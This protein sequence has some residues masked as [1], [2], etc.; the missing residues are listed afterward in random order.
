MDFWSNVA[1]PILLKFEG[2]V[3][4]ERQNE[5]VANHGGTGW[6]EISFN[7]A[8]DAT[9]SFID[10]NQGV[11][12]PFVPTGQYAT[13]VIFV[14]GPGTTAGTFYIDNVEQVSSGAPEVVELPVDF[15]ST[16]LTYDFLGFE[17]ADSAIESNPFQT[18]INTS[19]TVMRSTKTN[20]SQFFAGT[21][22]NLDTAIDF[23]G[24]QSISIKSYSP[25]ANI[26]VRMRLENADN[27]VG[28]ELDVMTTVANEWEE[29][30]FD[31]S[32]MNPTADF[33]RVVVFFELL[34]TFRETDQR[35]ISTIF[36][37]P[38]PEEVVT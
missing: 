16:T 30:V 10:G 20:G 3:N 37:W 26:P 11:G 9:K 5:V 29:L 2:G 22:L 14:D 35:I 6:E 17:G 7:F 8:T 4:G 15:E 32:T 18:G 21:F 36:N 38:D 24:T 1:V 27:S 25:K 34:L 28:I 12:E 31:F 13:L 33:V 19:A 23:S